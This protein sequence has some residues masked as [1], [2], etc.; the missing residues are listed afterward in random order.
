MLLTVVCFCFI[1]F[2]LYNLTF[3]IVVAIVTEKRLGTSEDI[4]FIVTEGR[5]LT[6]NRFRYDVFQYFLVDE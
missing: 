2:Y 1:L 4:P 6:R 3:F 5:Y